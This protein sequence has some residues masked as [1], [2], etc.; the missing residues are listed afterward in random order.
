M[1]IGRWIWR[2]GRGFATLLV[3]LT[4]LLPCPVTAEREIDVVQC[5]C[6]GQYTVMPQ[7]TDCRSLCVGSG[8]GNPG[9]P[10]IRVPTAEERA[11][12][13]RAAKR[14]AFD[15]AYAKSRELAKNGFA[16]SDRRNYTA[17]VDALRRRYRWSAGAGVCHAG[18]VSN[19][20]ERGSRPCSGAGG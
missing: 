13:Q 16:L 1:R 19:G 11:A 7:G 9:T 5:Y 17:A 8:Y 6:N 10:R 14:A 3:A 20:E 2:I 18:V 12:Q 4:M 15:T